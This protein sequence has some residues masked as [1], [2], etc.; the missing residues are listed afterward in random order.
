MAVPANSTFEYEVV[1]ESAGPSESW[2]RSEWGEGPGYTGMVKSLRAAGGIVPLLGA[3]PEL[4][5]D[6]VEALS[7]AGVPTGVM[8]APVV[9]AITDHE[10]PA[11]LA[12]SAK[13]G[14]QFAGFTML[15]LPFAVASIFEA[16]SGN[17]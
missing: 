12:E 14:A 6:A 1:L 9:P 7:R 11:I 3:S 15:R 4:R 5:L 10:M 17:D 2:I 8:V 13:R 16:P